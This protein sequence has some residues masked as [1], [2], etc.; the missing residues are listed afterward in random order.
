MSF[1]QRSIF[2]NKGLSRVSSSPLN[3]NDLSGAAELS[4]VDLNKANVT[5]T[6]FVKDLS[7]KDF[8]TERIITK[9]GQEVE[10]KLV[11]EDFEG[12]KNNPEYQKKLAALKIAME[13]GKD[14]KYKDQEIKQKRSYSTNTKKNVKTYPNPNTKNGM[15]GTN[16]E[17]SKKKDVTFDY[18]KKALMRAYKD[19]P[20]KGRRAVRAWAKTNGI[21]LETAAQ[22]KKRKASNKKIITTKKSESKGNWETL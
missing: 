3:N 2:S 15:W 17:G 7:G 18:A 12:G 22:A 9:K 19:D 13:Q 1:K 6:A 5:N 21:T 11:P 8:A 16:F 14:D 10:K 4:N 20:A